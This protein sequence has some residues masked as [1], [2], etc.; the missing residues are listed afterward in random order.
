[1][2]RTLFLTVSQPYFDEIKN[3]FKKFE[4]R[5]YKRF[6]CERFIDGKDQ[7]RDYDFIEIRNKYSWKKG[8]P[9]N[10]IRPWRGWVIEVISHGVFKNNPKKVF[11]IRLVE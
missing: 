9:R 11:A 6:W 2:T 7:P 8:D 5:E 3:G 10:I 4:Y 1:M